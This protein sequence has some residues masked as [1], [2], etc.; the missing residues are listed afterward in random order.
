MM[1]G[2]VKYTRRSRPMNHKTCIP[3]CCVVS[4]AFSFMTVLAGC[5]EPPDTFDSV[6]LIGKWYDRN[7]ELAFEITEAGEGYIAYNKLYCTVTSEKT[8]VY[9]KDSR[10]SFLGSFRYSIKN[11]VLAIMNGTGIFD[12]IHSKSPFIKSGAIPSGG[13][14][15]VELI[16]KWYTKDNPAVS[17]SF[18]ITELGIMT[19][20][21]SAEQYMAR[22]LGNIVFVWKGSLLQGDFQYY[23]THDEMHVINGEKICVGWESLSPFVKKNN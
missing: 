4:L 20:S 23:F 8:L 11:G 17:P 21:G 3:L 1:L 7:Y 9:V 22:V 13:S 12:D 10:G 2:E 5:G 19:I 6:E 15:P 16:G 14:V 18:E